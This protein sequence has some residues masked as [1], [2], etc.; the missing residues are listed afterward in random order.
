MSRTQGFPTA[1]DM[2]LA[3][4]KECR[5][6]GNVRIY[7]P[8]L[9]H[10]FVVCDL[11]RPELRWPVLLHDG[12]EVAG[13][14]RPKP[15]KTSEMEEEEDIMTARMF[16]GHKIRNFTDAEY[17]EFKQADWAAVQGEV[18]TVGPPGLGKM[19]YPN[20]VRALENL[21]LRYA[22]KYPASDCVKTGGG[23]AAREFLRRYKEY[24]NIYDARA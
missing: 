13:G 14:D 9:L 21:V 1:R 22:R 20:R 8:V 5:Y 4:G 7:W 2:A 6:A 17:K 16:R 24:K 23:R 11:V 19:R 10:T 15:F 12:V 18:W 3:L